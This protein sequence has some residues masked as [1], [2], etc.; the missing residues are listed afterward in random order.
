MI[1]L[2]IC[3]NWIIMQSVTSLQ[4]VNSFLFLYIIT[5]R[6]LIKFTNLTS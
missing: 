5:L 1:L 2:S 6:N 3:E 4:M